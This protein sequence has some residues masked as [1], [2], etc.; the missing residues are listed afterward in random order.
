MRRLSSRDAVEDTA[1]YWEKAKGKGGKE[2]GKYYRQLK[3][4]NRKNKRK[5]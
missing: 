4:T 2:F 5:K 3:R 1:R